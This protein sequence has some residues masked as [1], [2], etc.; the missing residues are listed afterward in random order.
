MSASG[1]ITHA[2]RVRSQHTAE[3]KLDEIS[4]AIEELANTLADMERRLKS[5]EA[6]AANAANR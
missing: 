6:L 3:A 5:T 1:A 2:R 4:K